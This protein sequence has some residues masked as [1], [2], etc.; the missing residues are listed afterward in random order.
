MY[1]CNA[2]QCTVKALTFRVSVVM[3][4]Q[5]VLAHDATLRICT[6]MDIEM[7]MDEFRKL[8]IPQ[9]IQGFRINTPRSFTNP[10]PEANRKRESCVI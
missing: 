2:V 8:Y 1:G 9:S 4:T 3:T 5:G 10:N 7:E 6:C